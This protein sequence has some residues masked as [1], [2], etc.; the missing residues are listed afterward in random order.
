M[1]IFEYFCSGAPHCA[2]GDLARFL[3]GLLEILARYVGTAAGSGNV[4]VEAA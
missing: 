4:M 2:R 1:S 3:D